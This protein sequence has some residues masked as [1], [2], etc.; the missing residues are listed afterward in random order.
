MLADILAT[1]SLNLFMP[2]LAMLGGAVVASWSQLVPE[3]ASWID[4]A[5]GPAGALVLA[6]VAL[7][8]VVRHLQ[9]KDKKVDQLNAEMIEQMRKEAEYWRSRV[10]K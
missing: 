10:S 2:L 1:K 9:K 7:F 6:L 8:V 4:K 3:D 5:M